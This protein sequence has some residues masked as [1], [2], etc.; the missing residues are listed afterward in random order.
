MQILVSDIGN[1]RVYIANAK[2]GFEYIEKEKE[3]LVGSIYLGTITKIPDSAGGVFLRIDNH[4]I[5]YLPL[6]EIP[7]D[8]IIHKNP[9]PD[10]SLRVGDRLLVQVSA[11][12]FDNKSPKLKCLLALTGKYVVVT[13]G[14][15]GVGCSK[16]LDYERRNLYIDNIKNEFK[17]RE[18]DSNKYGVLIRTEASNPRCK[19]KD[20]IDEFVELT[21]KLESIL[22]SSKF[23]KKE[24]ELMYHRSHFETTLEQM[25]SMQ[26]FCNRF[27]YNEHLK[28]MFIESGKTNKKNKPIQIE[29]TGNEIDVI[30]NNDDTK[31]LMDDCGFTYMHPECEVYVC[32]NENEFNLGIEDKLREINKKKVWVKSGCNIFIE[33]TTIGYVI[34]VNSSHSK[35]SQFRVNMDAACEVM[36]RIRL[37]DLSGIILVDFINMKTEDENEALLEYLREL[38][39]LDPINTQIIDITPLGIAEIVRERR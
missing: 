28:D 16:A 23:I 2:N 17:N 6:K 32:E 9:S 21:N 24:H 38:T 30:V 11:D 5:G 36:K 8:V 37:R 26:H 19:P 31:K 27:L 12:G 33:K 35:N 10:N 22:V 3:S 25:L 15:R 1:E 29:Y 7:E 14:R 34:D 4:V 39:T 20:V 13:L 18:F